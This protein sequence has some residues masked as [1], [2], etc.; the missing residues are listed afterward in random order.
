[1][2]LAVTAVLV[3]A[4]RR[5]HNTAAWSSAAWSSAAWRSVV[6]SSVVC[7]A[8]AALTVGGLCALA[9][10]RLTSYGHGLRLH[11]SV[12]PLTAAVGAAVVVGLSYGL[13]GRLHGAWARAISGAFAGAAVVCTAGAI[14]AVL[15]VAWNFPTS[16]LGVLP[17]LLGDGAAWLGGFSLGGRLE[18]D[19]S[20]PIPFLSGD[21][22]AGLITGGAWPGAYSLVVVPLVAAIVA[23]RRQLRGATED[24]APWAEFGR[25][26]VVN[27]VLWLVLAELTRL[28]FSGHLGAD[29]LSGSAGLDAASTGFVAALWGGVS[30][31]VG[32]ALPPVRG[33]RRRSWRS[34]R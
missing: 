18:A 12:S 34:S 15:V 22:G 20:S 23:G 9:G 26:A 2:P 27:A 29:Q 31:V 10:S 4:T 11:Y 33:V 1:V 32:L 16:T 24:A 21:L 19:L 7:A 25:A 8:T 13:A 14:C 28:R 30:A 3:L 6:W 17:G 5:R